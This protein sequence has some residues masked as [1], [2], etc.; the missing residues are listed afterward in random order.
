MSE[1]R[2]LRDILQEHSDVQ[3]RFWVC[4]I[5]EHGHGPLRVTV[6]WDADD[7]AHCTFPGC[8]FTSLTPPPLEGMPPLYHWSPAARRKRITGSG[9]KVGQAPV[10]HSPGWRAPYVCFAETPSWAWA[11]SGMRHERKPR[12][13][14]VWDLWQVNVNG[15]RGEPV[16]PFSSEEGHRWHEVRVHERIYKRH[17]WHVASREIM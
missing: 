3:V 11:L 17:L 14:G 1:R 12:Q 13:P 15:Y 8:T 2:H 6:E 4:P 5:R 16:P 10:T 9:L 7:V